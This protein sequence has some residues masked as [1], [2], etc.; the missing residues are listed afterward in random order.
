MHFALLIVSA[1]LAGLVNS[2][3]GGGTLLT[4]PA[5]LAV[6]VGPVAANATNTVALVPASVSAWYGYR[7][8]K[9]DLREYAWLGIPS[10]LGGVLGAL[11]VLKAGDALFRRLVPWLILGATVI[12]VVQDPLRRWMAT[13]NSLS[14]EKISWPAVSLFQVLVATYGGF[15]GAGIGIMML[16]AL[17][18]GG[19][20]D[21]H[22]MNRLKNF[23]AACINGVA[24]ATFIAGRRVDWELALLMAAASIPGGYAGAWVAQRVGQATVR[25]F[26]VFIGLVIG[27][28]MLYRPL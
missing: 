9:A 19:F 24:S 22:R 5:L 10:V 3:A 12:F 20:H 6:G 2:V 4:F 25:R 7:G 11:L 15:F 8:E 16:A 18:I 27:V 23:A 26:V 21:M 13:R 1:F 17:G 14:V 28:Y